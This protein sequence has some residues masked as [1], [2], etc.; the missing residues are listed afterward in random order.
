MV[1]IPFANGRNPDC[2]PIPFR[3]LLAHGN[4]SMPLGHF[5]MVSFSEWFPNAAAGITFLSLGLF[6]IYGWH[7][8]IVGGGGKP[9][10]CRLMGRCPSWSRQVN[11]GVIVLFLTVG[12]VNLGILLSVLLKG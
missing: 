7:R 8:G 9:A 4:G 12:V 1:R 5:I 10:S 11:I 2:I 6:K 3:R